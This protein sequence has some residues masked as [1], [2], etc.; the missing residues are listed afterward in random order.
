[1]L[2]KQDRSKSSILEIYLRH[3][4]CIFTCSNASQ[5]LHIECL[6][7]AHV[8]ISKPCTPNY[9]WYMSY[10]S[11]FYLCIYC[12]PRFLDNMGHILQ[13]M[14]GQIYHWARLPVRE[15][16]RLIGRTGFA[17]EDVRMNQAF[18]VQTWDALLHVKMHGNCLKYISSMLDFDLSC[19]HSIYGGILSRLLFRPK[20]DFFRKIAK[21]R[22]GKKWAHICAYT[23]SYTFFKFIFI[24]I[25]LNI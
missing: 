22:P 11:Y 18:Y 24:Y 25:L 6:I 8:F 23:I 19:F 12:S 2:W 20:N 5:V 15:I 21:K 7:H 3:F 10:I 14:G 9:I 17:Y 16:V 13:E 4:P 1:M